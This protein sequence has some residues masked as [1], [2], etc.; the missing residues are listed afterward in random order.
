VRCSG[1]HPAGRAACT[2]SFSVAL[3]TPVSYS[4]AQK[5]LH[6]GPEAFLPAKTRPDGTS[7]PIGGMFEGVDQDQSAP[8]MWACP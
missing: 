1:F 8:Q 7:V 3:N 5:K 2:Y 6:P 4:P